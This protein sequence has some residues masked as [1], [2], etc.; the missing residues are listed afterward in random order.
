M[1]CGVRSCWAPVVEALL[2]KQ[3]CVVESDVYGDNM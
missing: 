1:F 2:L 3:S